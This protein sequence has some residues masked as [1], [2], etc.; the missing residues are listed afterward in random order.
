MIGKARQRLDRTLVGTV[1]L[2][3][4]LALGCGG[5]AGSCASVAALADLVGYGSATDYEGAAAAP[6]L[7][8]T[9]ADVRAGGGCTDTDVA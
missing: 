8:S 6:G 9:T 4:A 1:D 2:D 5:T 3:H 7:D